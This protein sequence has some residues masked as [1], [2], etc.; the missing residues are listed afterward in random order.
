MSGAISIIDGVVESGLLPAN[1]NDLFADS[2]DSQNGRFNIQESQ[3]LDFKESIPTEFSSPYGLGIV[4]LALA[5]H[6]TFG[7]LIVFGVHDHLFDLIDEK[8]PFD[9]EK[10]NRLIS[11]VTTAHVECLSR[12][13]TVNDRGSSKTIWVVLVPKRGISAPVRLVKEIGK[14]KIGTLW[15]RER[16]EVLE[17]EPRHTAFLYSERLYPSQAESGRPVHRS[18]PPRPATLKDFINR[19]NVLDSLWDWFVLGDHPR[20]YLH[21]TGGSGKST[22]AFEFARTLADYGGHIR[23]KNGTALDYVLYISGKESELDPQSGKEKPFT[24]RQFTTADEQFAQIAYHSGFLDQSLIE[25]AGSKTVDSL[26]DELFNGFSGLVVI[27]DIDALTRKN[28]DT[29]EETLFLKAVQASSRTRVLYTLRH[30]PAH[31]IKSSIPIP[32][33]ES[34]TELPAFVAACCGQFQVPLP[35]AS[36][37]TG[38]AEAT[39]RLPLLIET[40]VLVR[41]DTGSYKEA[42]ATFRERGGDE[43]RRYLYQR[44][45]DRLKPTGRARQLLAGLLLVSEPISFSALSGLFQFSRDELREAIGEASA[46]FLT[47]QQS[48][49]GDTLHQ[50]TPPSIP[51]IDKASRELSYFANLE[52]RIAHFKTE[53]MKSNPRD[54]A[55]IVSMSG[56]L[57]RKEYQKVVDI[58]EAIPPSD[59]TLE[60]PRIRAMMG[61]AYVP[62]G[63]EHWVRAR[64]C[65]KH[66]EGLGYIDVF[67]MRHWFFLEFRSGYGYTEAER[68]CDRVLADPKMGPRYKSEFW[69][70]RASCKFNKAIGVLGA[71]REKGLGLLRESICDYFEAIAIGRALQDFDLSTTFGWVEAPIQRLLSVTGSDVDEYFL[72]FDVLLDRKHEVD[73]QAANLLLDYLTKSPVKADSKTTERVRIAC[74]RTLGKIRKAGKSLNDKP[75]WQSI[76]DALKKV[77]VALRSTLPNS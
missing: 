12:P 62:L 44:E 2:W 13:Y 63:P 27:D 76:V 77:S 40:V 38:L 16:H 31:A 21:G 41:R 58:A 5:F 10:F 51:F 15:V 39:S 46:I 65:F 22:L 64:Q 35:N 9:I 70:K 66:A 25:G 11:D 74:E 33:L 36:E 37:L 17:T 1:F 42:I 68:L 57:R 55:L 45:Y 69:S 28:V 52:A 7:G 47:A 20:L 19:G 73:Q 49:S 75:G 23:A 29:G 18:F 26:L 4:R 43:A 30:P 54:A 32:G 14:Y 60:N 8:G 24:F 56:H 71:S 48:E 59:K 6:N 72:I 34:T 50:L 67:M 61:C 3:V 53:G